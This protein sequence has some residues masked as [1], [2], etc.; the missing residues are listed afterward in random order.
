MA[1]PRYLLDT[2]IVLDVLL[3]RL[4]WVAE[5]KEL[6]RANDEG[7]LIGFIT[8]TTLTN[9]SYIARK[10]VNLHT[11]HDA[12]RTC[13]AAFQVCSV[14]RATL[15]QAAALAGTDFEDNVQIACANIA[16]LDAI[17]TRD[18]ADFSHSDI[19]VLTPAQA[20]AQ[21]P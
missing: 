2:N 17:V 16:A 19:A 18:A 11:A 20:L 12:V 9:I 5:A 10:Q 8:V 4:P 15:E 6:W 1:E 3:N 7:R 14:D 21:L 13:L